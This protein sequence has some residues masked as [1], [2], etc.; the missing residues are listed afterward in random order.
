MW[1]A[2]HRKLTSKIRTQRDI[3]LFRSWYTL[4]CAQNLKHT[5]E[6]QT[7]LAGNSP[8]GTSELIPFDASLDIL[9]DLQ[10]PEMPSLVLLLAL[11]CW[12]LLLLFVR[13]ELHISPLGFY[14]TSPFLV[15]YIE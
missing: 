11:P 1:L 6:F 14:Y 7:R 8:S 2:N 3:L 10:L 5:F 12:G 4:P 15:N 13:G 9:W